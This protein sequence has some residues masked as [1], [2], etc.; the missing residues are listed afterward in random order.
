MYVSTHA[1]M[2]A[3]THI[4][5]HPFQFHMLPPSFSLSQNHLLLPPSDWAPSGT[6]SIFSWRM[7]ALEGSGTNIGTI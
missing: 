3:Y 1:H 5:A 7:G 2:H 4:A 6:N